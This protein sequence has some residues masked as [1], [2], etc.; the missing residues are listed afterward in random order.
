M[1]PIARAWDSGERPAKF[2]SRLRGF[3]GGVLSEEGFYC[4]DRC[5][6]SE[7]GASKKSSTGLG[8]LGLMI[9][10]GSSCYLLR[11]VHRFDN[12]RGWQR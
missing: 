3:G 4:P 8:Y 6:V 2:D 11:P 5:E 12:G 1:H 10:S 9:D 7:R